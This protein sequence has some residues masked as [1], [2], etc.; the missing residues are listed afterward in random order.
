M[1]W[2]SA[3]TAFARLD[4]CCRLPRS[5]EPFVAS[6]RKLWAS[7]ELTQASP[8]ITEPSP[9]TLYA[10]LTFLSTGLLSGIGGRTLQLVPPSQIAA[11][12]LPCVSLASEMT[13]FPSRDIL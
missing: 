9:E 12:V 3:E 8:T 7:P 13:V 5:T 4:S 2:P 1:T 6:Q 11:D 10:V